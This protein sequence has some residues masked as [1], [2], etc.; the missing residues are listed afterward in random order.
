MHSSVLALQG[1]Q[2]FCVGKRSRGHVQRIHCSE[3]AAFGFIT[4]NP[5]DLLDVIDPN[6]D[7][8][9]IGPVKLN[10]R[11]PSKIDRLRHRL[12]VKERTCYESTGAIVQKCK[13]QSPLTR[14]PAVGSDKDA[15]VKKRQSGQGQLSRLATSLIDLLQD[16][17]VG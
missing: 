11:R 1:N 10:L 4:G 9:K 8:V 5:N 2:N 14:L 15:A 13:S 7:V 12:E 3:P 16:L 6:A 17:I